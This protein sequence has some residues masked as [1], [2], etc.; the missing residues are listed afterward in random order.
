MKKIITRLL[1]VAILLISQISMAIPAY[2]GLVKLS[3]PNGDEISAYLFGD[4]RVSWIESEDN[5]TLMVNKVGYLEYAMIDQKGGMTPSGVVAKSPSMRSVS[6]INFLSTIDKKIRYS[7]DQID[8]MLEITKSMETSKSGGVDGL[9]IG[10]RKLLVI[11]VDYS[12]FSFTYTRQNFEDLFNQVGYSANLS[13]GSVR[14]YFAASSYGKLDLQCTV[15]GPFTLPQTRKFYGEATDSMNDINAKQ[16]ILDA[17]NAADASVDFSIFDNDHNLIVDGVH[18]V[19]AGKGQHNGGGTD[20]IW[21]HRSKLGAQDFVSNEGIRI[22]DYSCASEKNSTGSMSGVGVHS[23]EFGHVLGLWDYYDADYEINGI[24]KTFGDFDIM[25]GGAYNNNEKTPPIYNAYSKVFLGW[26][27]PYIIDTNMLMDITSFHST[28]S[29]LVFQINTPIN[30]EY[31]LIENKDYTGWNGKVDAMQYYI[32]TTGVT[33][34]LLAI[35]VDESTNALGWGSNCLNCYPNRNSV[36]IMSADGIYNGIQSSNSWNYSSMSNMFYPGSSNITSLTDQTTSNLLSWDSSPS[37]VSITQIQRL[38]NKNI[39]FKT[40]GGA[41]YGVTI[42]TIGV[43]QITQT[44]VDLSGSA[45]A[46]VL[47][48]ATIIEKG[49]AINTNPYPRVADMKIVVTGQTPTFNFTLT[50]L[51]PGT[52]Y[53]CR[54][55]G[56]NANGVSYGEQITFITISDPITNNAIIDSNFAACE[57]GE[58]PTLI[59]T[60]PQGGSGSFTYRWLE[61]NDGV[62][63]IITQNAGINRDYTPSQMT[64]PTYYKR[65]AISAEKSDTSQS[66]YVPIVPMTVA[67]EVAIENDSI[68]ENGTTGAITLTNNVGDVVLWQRKD[69]NEQWAVIDV[70]NATSFSQILDAEGIYQY[71]V[72]VRNGACPTKTTTPVS[73]YVDEVGINDIDKDLINF[74]LY[75]NPV[76]GEF[77]LDVNLESGKT[78]DMQIVNLLGKMVYFKSDI[79]SKTKINVSTLESGAYILVLRDGKR[80]VGRKQIQ[81]IQ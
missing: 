60:D 2:P 59:G 54:A 5:Y 48:D 20:A 70:G 14:D 35:H 42:N 81:V 64:V 53:Y 18:I 23:H 21:A 31:F 45:S 12:D 63:W 65:V 27:S 4:E 28:D 61:S 58:M 16:M 3:Q 69:G 68:I 44:S 79:N 34:G 13:T 71:R 77:T 80:I 30:G 57:T 33:S 8:I 50:N 19:Y 62:N 56:I 74:N 9:T 1:F 6:D 72:R 10:I 41:D 73:V 25:D 37:N 17:C 15:V 26:A 75:P 11:L 47:G 76:N 29:A 46:S 24:S 32:N 49:F 55:Y 51:N 22:I 38:P 43:D 36:K 7:K 40:N 39:T 66:K 52:R 78:I 67:G